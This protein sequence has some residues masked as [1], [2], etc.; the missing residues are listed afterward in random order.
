MVQGV[1]K[2]KDLYQSGVEAYRAKDY[3]KAIRYLKCAVS[4]EDPYTS[5]YY[6]AEAHC[7]LGVIY[8]FFYPVTDHISL[9]KMQYEAALRIDPQTR[10]AKKH[11]A[12]VSETSRN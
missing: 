6:Y 5:R 1:F 4:F 2:M 11:L 7:L 9:A 3:E 8:Q 12:E 10:I